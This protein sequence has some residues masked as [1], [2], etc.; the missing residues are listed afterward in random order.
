MSELGET[1]ADID[2][3]RADGE[4][5]RQIAGFA[6]WQIGA[7]LLAGAAVCFT[8]GMAFAWIVLG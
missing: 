5:R 6:P 4:R 2:Q 1:I 8:A 3:R 7:V